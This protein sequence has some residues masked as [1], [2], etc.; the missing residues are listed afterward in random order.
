MPSS[1][2]AIAGKY[3]FEIMSGMASFMDLD[4]FS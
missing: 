3:E 4:S 1:I 2:A